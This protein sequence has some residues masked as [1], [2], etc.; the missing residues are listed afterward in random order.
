[1]RAAYPEDP[2]AAQATSAAL[3]LALGTGP[4]VDGPVS[5][6]ATLELARG[7]GLAALCWLRSGALVR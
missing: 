4:G 2:G 3:A 5:W 7:E 6:E 1:M